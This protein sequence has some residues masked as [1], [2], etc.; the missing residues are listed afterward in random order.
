VHCRTVNGPLALVAALWLG[1]CG[2]SSFPTTPTPLAAGPVTTVG[3]GSWSGGVLLSDG[4]ITSFNMTLIARSLGQ[5]SGARA[6]AQAVNTTEVSG[7]FRLGTGLAG[8][9]Q[10]LLEGTLQH[11]SFAGTLS[12]PACTRS[13]DGPITESTVAWIPDGPAPPG[14]P[15][16]FSIQL[17]RPRGP[18]CQ[19]VVSLSQQAF[20]GSGGRGSVIVNTGPSCAWAAESPDSWLQVDDGEPKLGSGRVTF[21]VLPN[22]LANREGRLRIA[23]ANQS[24][25]VSQGPACSFSVSPTAV[26]VGARAGSG[27]VRVTAN[28][29]CE[30]T[31]RSTVP[32]IAVSPAAGSGS[33]AVTYTFESNAGTP[34]SGSFVAAGQTITVTQD[35][36]CNATVTPLTGVFGPGGRDDTITVDIGAGCGWSAESHDSWIV[37]GS[38]GGRGPGPLSYT[39]TANAGPA[40]A[41]GLT[42]AGQRV[43]IVQASGCTYVLTSTSA[44][45]GSGLLTSVMRPGGDRGIATVTASDPACAWTLSGSEPWITF[46]GSQSLTGTGTRTVNY[47][48][49]AFGSS[50][51]GPSSVRSG[52]VTLSGEGT[53]AV[54]VTFVQERV[55]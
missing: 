38:P 50:E 11:G 21:T 8:T 13:Y 12:T 42:V 53:V 14:C 18:D 51:P 41:G 15:L 24:F 46:D 43:S 52:T 39:I 1:G 40:R 23:I 31:T 35:P 49:A 37:P 32:W 22:A 47:I 30:W 55:G 33:G 3:G 2:E 27:T 54:R 25:L 26:T 6:L 19:Y 5:E 7:N 45:G 10:G 48:V 29:G 44:S 28:S 36:A 17:P 34:R 4:S 20:A 9:I 16:T